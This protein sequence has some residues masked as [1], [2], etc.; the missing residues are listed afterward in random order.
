MH[1]TTHITRIGAKADMELSWATLL[2]L[3]KA[4]Y[5]VGLTTHVIEAKIRAAAE[6]LQVATEVLSVP[7]G[8]MLT[9]CPPLERPVTVLSRENIAPLNLELLDEVIQISDE[10]GCTDE[11]L[12]S[13]RN[14][15][16]SVVIRKP[17]WREPL[18]LLAYILSSS[19]F[20]VFFRGGSREVSV[21]VQ[22]GLIVG[23]IAHLFRRVRISSRLF[24][25]TSALG[26]AFLIYSCEP[27]IGSFEEWIPM[28]AGL[29]IL[30]PGVALVDG[31]NELAN[32]HLL[33]GAARMA[34]VAVAFLALTFGT[35]V[36]IA[37]ARVIPY[38]RLDTSPQLADLPAWAP[39]AA[40]L[41]VGLGSMIRFRASPRSLMISILASAVAFTASRIGRQV[42][43]DLPGAFLAA[44]ILAFLGN[45][46]SHL[47]RH[48]AELFLIPGLAVL[49]PGS[50][51]IRSMRLLLSNETTSGIAEA[52]QMLLV[53]MALVSGLLFAGS[54]WQTATRHERRG[55][56]PS[57][58]FSR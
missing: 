21:A 30:L 4:L 25:L 49:V 10:L 55:L 18:I 50:V 27:W 36:G 57:A 29:I 26:A 35:M 54:I 1:R 11:P 7:T 5:H 47:C 46:Y 42:L 43:G 12:D 8:L 3:G 33:A 48:A 24:E 17:R 58:I 40:V 32:G 9:F 38:A 20:A 52:F 53:A 14:R 34:G 56:T 19:A 44:L 6:R 51:G 15:L 37:L 31:V 16:K 13:Y 22:V 39:F 45:L 41:I 2:A 23:V 28:A